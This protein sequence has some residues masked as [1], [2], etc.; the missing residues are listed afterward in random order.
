MRLRS[1]GTL[2]GLE[3]LRELIPEPK[4]VKSNCFSSIDI[5][6]YGANLCSISMKI[7]RDEIQVQNREG[8]LKALQVEVMRTLHQDFIYQGYTDARVKRFYKSVGLKPS[9]T[10]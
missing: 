9:E 6:C 5:L 3:E 1:L 10:K 7:L 4:Q 8:T 2:K